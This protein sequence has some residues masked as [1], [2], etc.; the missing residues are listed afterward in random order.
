KVIGRRAA[1]ELQPDSVI[2]L[3]IG[4]PDMV[5]SVAQEEGVADEYV[6]TLEMGIWGGSAAGGLDFGASRNADASIAMAN[7]FDFYDGNG[8]DLSVLG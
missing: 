4:T 3:G 8:L 6:T 5:A 1:M 2:N 7:Q